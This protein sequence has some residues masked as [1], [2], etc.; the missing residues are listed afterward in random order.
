MCK[1]TRSII[2]YLPSQ[3]AF[4]RLVM[5]CL[6]PFRVRSTFRNTLLRASITRV[7]SAFS[8]STSN[9]S[10]LAI[11]RLR[12]PCYNARTPRGLKSSSR[13]NPGLFLS[14]SS[15]LRIAIHSY[16]TSAKNNPS[17]MAIASVPNTPADIIAQLQSSF[18]KAKESGDVLFFPSTV[19]KHSEFGVE[20]CKSVSLFSRKETSSSNP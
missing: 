15:P 12:T 4:H 3:N 5:T 19:H 1:L 7:H 13:P 16:S 6:C 2:S 10:S 14:T 11:Q 18:D 9:V 8:Y 17:R 20:V